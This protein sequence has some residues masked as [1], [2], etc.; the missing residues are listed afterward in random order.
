MVQALAANV[1]ADISLF[2]DVPA[3]N[4]AALALA[5]GHGMTPV[6]ETGRMYSKEIPDVPI[7]KMFGITSFELG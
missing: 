5:R 2:L 6:F 4:P 3:T 1:P 7:H